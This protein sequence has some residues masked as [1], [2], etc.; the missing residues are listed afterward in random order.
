MTTDTIGLLVVGSCRPIF[1]MAGVAGFQSAVHDR[2]L[3]RRHPAFHFTVAVAMGLCG[4]RS[5]VLIAAALQAAAADRRKKKDPKAQN[6]KTSHRF[7]P[8]RLCFLFGI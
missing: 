7:A 5:I 4:L 3:I 6:V 8:A 1:G 2:E